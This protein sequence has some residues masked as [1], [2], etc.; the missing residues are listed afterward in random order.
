[1]GGN[2]SYPLEVRGVPRAERARRAE[3]ALAMVKLEG[4]ASRRPD[5][6]SG[7]QRQRVALARALVFE[8]PLVLMDE[9]LGALDKQ[10]REHMQ[11]ELKDLHRR[12]GTTFIYVTHDQGEALTLSDRVAVFAGGELQQVDTPEA[13][14]ERPANRFVASFVGDAVALAGTLQAGG[15]LARVALPGGAQLEGVNVQAA[16]PG[17][18]VLAC[19]RPERIGVL[20]PGATA[21]NTLAATALDASYFGDHVRLRCALPGQGPIGFP[22]PLRAL[23]APPPG[24]AVLLELPSRHLRL[25]A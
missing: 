19:I 8:P 9:P 12:L 5:Q 7:G 14:Y 21:V 6:L 3:Q 10:L 17:T 1:V 22:L 2:V 20:P 18:P 13:L 11:V 24:T 25:Y 23:P 16:A 4:V 15:E